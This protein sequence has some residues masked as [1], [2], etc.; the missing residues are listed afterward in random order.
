MQTFKFEKD[1]WV[2]MFFFFDKTGGRVASQLLNSG[3]VNPPQRGFDV[4]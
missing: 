2:N 4:S 3:R 1:T